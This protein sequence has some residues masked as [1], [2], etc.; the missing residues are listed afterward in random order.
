MKELDLSTFAGVMKGSE[1]G[2]VV[3]AGTPQESRLY[4]MVEKGAMPK[5][6]KPLSSEQIA[7]LREW[8]EAGAPSRRKPRSLPPRL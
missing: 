6:G 3:T 5:G 2:A 8:I 7:I 4:E 1:A